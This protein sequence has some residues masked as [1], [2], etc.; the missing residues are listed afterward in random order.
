MTESERKYKARAY[1][2]EYYKQNE[3]KTNSLYADEDKKG[4]K[5][6]VDEQQFLYEHRNMDRL[7]IAKHL[8]RTCM[9]IR[10]QQQRLGLL[11]VTP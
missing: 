5:W 9:S 11:R 2:H 7:E 4:Q 10:N 6:T 8:G 3:L 1:R